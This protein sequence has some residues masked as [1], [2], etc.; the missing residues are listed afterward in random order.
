MVIVMPAFA[1][2]EEGNPPVV[3]GVVAGFEAA[4]APQM[5]HGV[6]EPGDVEA[7]GNSQEDSPPDPGKA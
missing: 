2:G 5:S 7:D 3:G 1:S 4:R 6:D